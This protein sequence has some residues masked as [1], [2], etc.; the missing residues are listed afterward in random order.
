M[1]RIWQHPDE[2]TTGKRY[3]R[4]LNQLAER[5]G[6]LE[7]RVREF[8][9]GVEAMKDES[10]M[11]TSRRSFMKLM[12]ASMALAGLAACR[13][14]EIT[15]KPY[16]KAPEWVI[17]GKILFYAT[18]MPR[19]VA[20]VPRSFI[21]TKAGRRTCRAISSTPTA[22]A[23]WTCRQASILNLYDPTAPRFS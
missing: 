20:G 8:P 10:D 9:D 13:R 2:P 6:T 22:M 19:A 11:E 21:R 3:W 15:I 1:K 7:A 18:A 16:A 5:P 14:P 4:S 12:G 17:P 23:V